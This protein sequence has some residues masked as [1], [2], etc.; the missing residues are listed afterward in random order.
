M[1]LL[2]S[3]GVDYPASVTARSLLVIVWLFTILMSAYYTANL[4]A[5]LTAPTPTPHIES[6]TELA[7]QTAIKPLIKDATALFQ[8][9]NVITS[10]SENNP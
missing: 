7:D 4:A 8:L 1:C 5:T 2:F 9:F 10:S 3:A 6:I